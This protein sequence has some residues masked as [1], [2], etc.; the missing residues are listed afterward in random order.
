M[1]NESEKILDKINVDLRE[2]IDH[3]LG[4]LSFEELQVLMKS[5][6]CSIEDLAA[7]VVAYKSGHG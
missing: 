1:N 2:Y 5:L 4:K 7:R 3:Q 6:S